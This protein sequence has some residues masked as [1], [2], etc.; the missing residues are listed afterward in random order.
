MLFC[1]MSN[2]SNSVFLPCGIS[3][4]TLDKDLSISSITA[5]AEQHFWLN[6]FNES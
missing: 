2:Y 6:F 3:T 5:G 4:I 1:I